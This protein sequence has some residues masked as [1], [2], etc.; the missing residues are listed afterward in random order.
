MPITNPNYANLDYEEMATA[1]GLKAKHVPLLVASF[2]EEAKPL[3]E[4]IHNAIEN[5][6]YTTLQSAAHSIK[7]SSGNLRFSELYDMAREMELA[8]KDANDSFEYG[9]YLEAIRKAIETI[10]A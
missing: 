5:K 6:E 3:L 2:L 1:I 9:A 8:A 4:T 10:S 7:G